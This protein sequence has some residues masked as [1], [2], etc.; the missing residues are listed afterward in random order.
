VRAIEAYREALNLDPTNAPT[1]AAL[2]GLLHRDGEPVL[3]AQVLEPIYSDASEFERLIDVYEVMTTHTTPDEAARRVELLHQI[4]QLHETKLE[5]Y[6]AAFEA[7]GRALRSDAG[8]EI[9]LGNLERLADGTRAWEPLARLYE[10]ELQKILDVPRQV[11]LLLRLARVYEEELGR[12]EKAIESYRRVLDADGDNHQAITALDRLFE[13]G[14]RWPELA[15]ILRREVRLAGTDEEVL[16]IEFR[17]GQIYETSIRDLP[18]AIDVYREILNQEPTHAKTQNALEL[19]FLDGAYQLEI[20]AILEPLYRDAAEWEKLHKIHEVQLSKLT[21][22][23]DRQAMYQRLAE[24]SEHRLHDAERAFRW[25]GEALGEEPRSEQTAGELERL[26]REHGL[27]ADLV[28]VYTDV[29]Q[30]R[31]DREVERAL[32]LRVAR[33]HDA[34]LGDLA[35]AE[36]AYLR[37][38]GLDG[39]DPDALEAL[40]RIYETSGMWTELA[41][42][43]KRRV[44]IAVSTE[45]LVQLLFRLGHVQSDV[46]GD[47]DAAIGC[48]ERILSEDTR[49]R[50]ALE[51]L[52]RV[53]F[54]RE[55]W[56]KLHD[57]YEGMVDVARDDAEMA[58]VYARMARLTSEALVAP[59]SDTRAVE[60][61]LRVI[62]LRG[63]DPIGLS[64]L[65]DLYERGEDWRELVDVLERQVHVHTEAAGKVPLY[66]RLGRV[67]A[68]RLGR[69]RSSL[70]AWLA[71]YNLAPDDLETLRALAQI[72]R[73]T[74]AWEDLS[75]TLRRIIDVGQMSEAGE[76][77]EEELVELYA[78]L[79]DLEG[80]TL[81]RTG[82]AVDAWQRV[83]ALAPRDFRALGALESLFAREG[84]WEEGIEVLEKKADALEDPQARIDTLLQAARLWEDKVENRTEAAK[85][86]E[87]VRQA[88]PGNLV[89]SA[90]LESIYRG[91]RQW[92]KLTEV[93]L[94]RVEHTPEAI[95]RIGILQLVARIYEQEMGDSESAFVVLQAAFKED[96]ANES[97]SK[98]LE[99]L[100]SAANKWWDL[101]E[102]YSHVVGNLEHEDPAKAADLWVKIA[103][104][105]GDHV[106]HLEYAIHSAQS[107]L[108]LDPRHLGALAALAD[109]HRKRGAFGELIAVLGQHAEIET[110]PQRRV[111]LYLTL[112]DLLETQVQDPMQAIA[113]YN[114]A[115]AVDSSTMDALSALDRLYRRHEMWEQLIGVLEKKAWAAADQG[116]D[117]EEITRLRL[118]VGRLWDERLNEPARAIEAYNKVRDLEPRNLLALRAL[119][120]LYERTNQSDRYLEALEQQLD[121]DI[122]DHEKI[123]LY[124]RVASAWEER[125]GKLDRAAE[126]L[127]KIL[128]VDE[129]HTPSYRELERLYRQD[130]RWDALVDTYRRHVL[131]A[132]DPATRMDLYCA[133]GQVYEEELRDPDRAIE[134]YTDVLTFDADEP[135]ALEALGRLYEKIEEWDKAVDAMSRLVE[136][137]DDVA[138]KVELDH[139]IGAIQLERL[140]DPGEA[141]A[142]FLQALGQDP[143]YVPT[144][145]ALTALY[146]K[147]GD[148]QKAAQMM[149]RA[150][151][152][153]QHPLEKIKLLFEAAQIYDKRLHDQARAVEYYAQTIAHD[154][155]H[156]EA[157]EPLAEIYFREK[158][159]AELEPILDMLAR[160]AAQLRKDNKSLNEL[161]YRVARTSDEL[162]NSDKGLR[163]YKLAYDL[164]STYLPTL[165]G[166]ANLMFRLQDWDGAGKIYQTILV[167]HRESQKDTDV[168]EIYYRL[169]QVRLKLGERK[170]A[171]NMFEKALEIDPAHRDTL[172]AVIDLQTQ[173]GDWEAVVHAK[174]SLFPRVTP[175]EKF[176][177]LDEIGDVYREKLTNHQK[178]IAAYLEALELKPTNHV[179]LHKVLEVYTDTKQW[180]KAVE[181][182]LRFT[183][184]ETDPLV[185][186]KYYYAAGVTSRDE[187][188]S[189]DEAVEYFNR[190]LDEYFSAADRIPADQMPKYL[191]AFEAIDRILTN[192]KDWPNLGR[193]YRAM[194][195]R[196]P[197]RKEDKILVLLW[198]S[199][200][201][202]Y[203]SRLKEYKA[204]AQ[205]FEV[206]SSL[207][208]EN[209]QRR[210]ILAEL[211]VLAG[212]DFADKAIEQHMTMIKA[213][214]FK[215]DSYKALRKIYMESHQYDKA[216][217]ICNTLNF[218]KK[219]DAEELQFYE[220]YKPKGFVRAK[221]RFTDEIWRK[222][223]HPDQD[224]YVSAIYGAIWQG[225]AL[226]Q[227]F[228]FKAYEKEFGLKRKE[229]RQVETDQLLFSKVFYYTSQVLNVAPP[230]VYL[231]PEQ[232]GE[233]MLAN[234]DE[235]GTLVPAFVVR[236]NLLSG[237]PEKEIAFACAKELCYMRP[238]HYLKKTLTTKT[239]LKI[240]FLSA[241]VLVQPN[242]PVKPEQV[243]LVQQY[244]PVLRSKIQPS[245]L[246]QLHVVVKRFL[247][248]A[249][250]VDLVKWGYAVDATAHRVGF[251]L[252]G[253][254][255][256]A[257]KMV[258]M[259]PVQVGGPQAKDKVKELV[260]YSIS[261]EYFA[262]RQHLGTIIG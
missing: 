232:P 188:K 72:Y 155:E 224:R 170:K 169:G 97:T 165:L 212:P 125:F 8:N 187:L 174:R 190:A 55:E 146:K 200:G 63:E 124:N 241:M 3:A 54:K 248:N 27:W 153:I 84:Q 194:I 152:Q 247:S 67:W 129:R 90:Q 115:L 250:E 144:M 135:R 180:K 109:F 69:E 33:V 82:E 137:T 20:G 47:T 71:A 145:V 218:L 122:A 113:A 168:V 161:Y 60:L 225:A 37:V 230:D 166:R 49:N 40:D 251:L 98:E 221:S 179:L 95:D 131:A 22:L 189:L 6:E 219:A 32:F 81:G 201:E 108:R 104:W 105:Y 96:Y 121:A 134:A 103:R 257:A 38:L 18:A 92:D 235:K 197:Q 52:E 16:A 178:S 23:A 249:T 128:I 76:V 15:E 19:L 183:E 70:E 150:E 28:A 244:V 242:F 53:Y 210:E 74:Q 149:V 231:Q 160:K 89:A 78:Q 167:Q 110:D 75:L 158:R 29:L 111:D 164:D 176:R 259:E 260:L 68:E 254:L 154:P 34:E 94:E 193:A 202:I 186:G 185:R 182:M 36:E 93:L 234:I 172:G 173:Q 39:K 215:I 11:D 198:H 35:R 140:N 2:D 64:A 101:L 65:A 10:A 208:P 139:R 88:E 138:L 204:A 126:A 175:D 106:S 58:D 163:Y 162:G 31:P 80:E 216:W 213:E 151:S 184:I 214:P 66:K 59:D 132:G 102:D 142:R 222:V 159:W 206:A 86:Y 133:M 262:V 120:R 239:D 44:E 43:L 205:A 62:D 17:L 255:E 41:D 228:P 261:E 77:P 30:R 192:K 195:K 24:I 119:E 156:V 229:K 196:M 116:M 83:L 42:I 238:E 25:W 199:L 4:A 73:Q 245:W 61:W 143:T 136:V 5:H 99:R 51:R 147:R 191:K 236:A 100:A 209:R 118:E 107:A 177:L 127:E 211:Y 12:P 117:S 1:I 57:I 217:C 223:F 220:Q 112:A 256:V 46:L 243:S 157:G 45:D 85:V 171:L 253:D 123:G 237:R 141:E 114:A 207:E 7:Y 233:I 87:R 240:A 252:C 79:G 130:Q 203:R 21:E 26:A 48:Y 13:Q 181:V 56:Q 226:V 9:T 148:W 91:D 227:A 258:S 246:E 50:Q 14:Q